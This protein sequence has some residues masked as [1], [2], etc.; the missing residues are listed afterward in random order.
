[1]ATL[2]VTL[3]SASS[4]VSP[5][6]ATVNVAVVDPELM[7]TVLLPALVLVT[8]LP[9]RATLRFTVRF[10][11]G[12]ALAVTVKVALA[13]SVT[14]APLLAMVTDGRLPSSSVI[15]KLTVPEP[16]AP[17][18]AAFAVGAPRLTA[19]FSLGSSVVSPVALKVS[20]AVREALARPVKVIVIGLLVSAL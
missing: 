12:A 16:V 2:T 8:K 11:S 7:V 4:A 19:I 1:M 9:T 5:A 14:E 18:S 13:P 6:V 15:E 10:A 20:V 17:P 3:P